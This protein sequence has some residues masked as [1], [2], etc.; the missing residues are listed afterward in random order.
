M[1]LFMHSPKVQSV[2][3]CFL[4]SLNEIKKKCI[5]KSG[6]I[7]CLARQGG[8]FPQIVCYCPNSSGHWADQIIPF[9]R[10]SYDINSRLT[11]TQTYFYQGIA[12]GKNTD[13]I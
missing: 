7:L 10:H 12:F 1:D 4:C 6:R 3:L 9:D 5:L 11:P 2:W 8:K 13:R